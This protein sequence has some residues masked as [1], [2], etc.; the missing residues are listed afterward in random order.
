MFHIKQQ[1]KKAMATRINYGMIGLGDMGQ[2][3]LMHAAE[4]RDRIQIYAVY[5]PDPVRLN[6]ASGLFEPGTII[7]STMEELLEMPRVDAV[8]ISTPNNT[9]ADIAVAAFD[10]GKHVFCEKPLA[11]TLE[12]CDRIIAAGKR[13]GKLLQVGMVY[14]YSNFYRKLAELIEQ[15]R[16]GTPYMA[17]CK[18]FRLPFPVGRGREWR[19]RSDISGGA[20]IEK[21]CHHFDIFNW[22]LKSPPARVSAF[23]NI[24]AL[25]QSA[26]FERHPWVLE[27]SNGE[28]DM[29]F[30]PDIVDN[31][32]IMTE[33]HS[34]AKAVL[35][36]SFISKTSKHNDLEI[37]FLGTEGKLESFV[38][39][40]LITIYNYF[41]DRYRE[42]KV[43]DKVMGMELIAHPGGTNQHVEFVQCVKT[44]TRPFCSGPEARQSFI[45][46]EAAERSIR[47]QRTID[48]AAENYPAQANI[49]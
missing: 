25:R 22:V 32:L 41:P 35:E 13:A 31:A 39:N 18:E 9:H 43:T 44:N 27:D 24:L 3:H 45:I 40:E 10:A 11:T 5:E 1:P 37:G 6:A 26:D 46:A 17:W 15:G 49:K 34:G 29:P 14:R 38:L 36:L 47:E 8:V 30:S 7:C 23:G 21:N 12:D 19:Y 16:I 20:I 4:L 33:Y 48:L 42:L 2:V 28:I